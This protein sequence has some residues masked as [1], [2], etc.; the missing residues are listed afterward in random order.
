M[1]KIITKFDKTAIYY[2]IEKENIEIIK[3]LLAN[4]KLII[5]IINIS[6]YIIFKII[7]I[8]FNLIQKHIFQ[9]YLKSYVSI[10]FIIIYSYYI[11]IYNSTRLKN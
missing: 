10:K 3:L 1:N 5:N 11:R 8:N 7:N 4:N 2:A 6:I 9:L